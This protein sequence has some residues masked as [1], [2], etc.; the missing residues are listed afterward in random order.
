MIA[1]IG[2]SIGSAQNPIE[3]RLQAG[4]GP[5]L[6]LPDA[7]ESTA[8]S[9]FGKSSG[10]FRINLTADDI[11]GDTDGARQSS[12]ASYALSLRASQLIWSHSDMDIMWDAVMSVGQA[13]YKL[14]DG[15]DPLPEPISVRFDF[16]TLTPRLYTQFERPLRGSSVWG[17]RSGGGVEVSRTRVAITSALLDVHDT[18]THATGFVF[19]DAYYGWDSSHNGQIAFGVQIAPDS[20]FAF[21]L[22]VSAS[23]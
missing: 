14:P 9:F 13:H 11:F 7:L 18:S 23:Y 8:N 15:A 20:T 6:T 1:I 5:S 21:N 2:P 10:G 19:T 16:V 22:G 17:L 4:S 12:G 3:V